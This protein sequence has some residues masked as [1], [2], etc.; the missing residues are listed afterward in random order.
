MR[1][2]L[3]MIPLM[4]M[5]LPLTRAAAHTLFA[6]TSPPQYVRGSH[7]WTEKAGTAAQ[8]FVKGGAGHRG[9]LLDAAAREAPPL[10]EADLEITTV[11]VKKGGCGIHNGRL[12]HGSD[13]NTSKTVPRRGLGIHFVPADAVFRVPPSRDPEGEGGKTLAARAA[14]DAA[15]AAGG[16]A[17]LG[18]EIDEA[19]FPVTWRPEEA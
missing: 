1:M 3:M 17:A 12:W 19:L 18:C 11:G 8:F 4:M 2:P 13:R 14:L 15:E 10:A 6:L 16:G 5:L 9:L 7:R